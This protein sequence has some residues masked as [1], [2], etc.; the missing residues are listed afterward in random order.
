MILYILYNKSD[1]SSTTA[2]SDFIY[3]KK[4]ITHIIIGTYYLG[5]RSN[6]DDLDVV[7]YTIDPIVVPIRIITLCYYN[8]KLFNIT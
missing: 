2:H 8:I 3:I 4:K 7:K 1:L 5:I 6:Q